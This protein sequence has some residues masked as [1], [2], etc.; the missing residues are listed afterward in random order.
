[1]KTKKCNIVI[2]YNLYIRNNVLRFCSWAFGAKRKKNVSLTQTV[3]DD[4][5]WF[6]LRDCP[7]LVLPVRMSSTLL[8]LLT[9]D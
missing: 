7:P 5:F 4:D 6:H 1:M 3:T 2:Y 9:Q 8:N